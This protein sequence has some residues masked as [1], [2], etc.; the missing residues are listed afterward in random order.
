MDADRVAHYLELEDK[1]AKIRIQIH[2]KLDNQKHI[3][4]ILSA[5]EENIQNLDTNDTSKN[6]VH[7]MVSLM[8]L[9]DQAIDPNTHKIKDLS[10][11]SST[12]YLLDIIF[13]YAPKQLLKSKFSE[14]LTKIAPCITDEGASAALIRSAIGCLES[15]LIAQDA[16]IWNN[17]Q[18]LTVTPRRGLQGL[19]ELSLDP[20]PKIRKRAAEAV[21]NIL[22]NPPA[23]PT[24]E[25]VASIF[26]ASF[27]IKSLTSVMNEF[28][29]TSNKKLR[30]QSGPNDLNTKIIHN[31][32]FISKVISSNQ[33]PSPQ[34]EP[35][36]DLLLEVTKSSDQFL[37]TAAFECFESLFN[38]LSEQSSTLGL[39]DNKFLNVLEIIYSL[40]PSNNDT[41][42][43]GAWIAVVVKSLSSY[44]VHQPLKAMQKIP[45]VFKLIS[46]Y[47]ASESEEIYTSASQCLIAILTNAIRDELLLELPS[48]TEATIDVVDGLLEEMSVLITDF[49]SIKYTH[50][51]KEILNVLAAA[52]TK[53]RHRANPSFI[54]LLVIVDQWRIN[55][56]NYMEY[57]NEV[58]KVIGSAIS[59]MGPDIVLSYLPLNL[60]NPT[61]E[62]PGR[63]W[64]LPILRDYTKNTRLLTF[65][66]EIL[67]LIEVF[68]DKCKQLN[69][70]SVQLKVFQTVIDQLWSTLPRF[71]ELP[72]DL[73]ESFTSDFASKLSSILYSKVELR[74]TICHALKMLVDSNSAYA[75]GALADNILLQESFP[76]QNAKDNLTYLSK[77]SP[78]ILSVLFNV[79][80]QTAPNARGYILETIE[81]FIKITTEEDLQTTFNKVCTLLNSAMDE[82]SENVQKGKP[83][84][85]ATLLDL[86]VCMVKYVPASSY[87]ALF[88]IFSITV[89]SVDALTQKRAYRIVT[90]LSE[91]DAGFEALSGFISDITKVFVETSD[92]TQTSTRSVRLSAI[93]ALVSMLPSNQMD[94][95]VKVVPEVILA[96]KDVNEKSRETAF[97]TLIEMGKKMNEPNSVVRLSE[98]PGYD[99]TTPDQPSSVTEFFKIMSAGLIGESQHMVS[100]TITA[101]AC[102]VFEFKDEIDPSMLLEIYDTIQ[103][104]LT[105]NS[106]EIAKSAIGYIKVCILGLPVELM[107]DKVPELLPK[108]L[109]WSNEHT[110]HFKAKVKNIIER[111][112]RRFGYELVEQAFPEEDRKL[113]TNIRKARNRNSKKGSELSEGKSNATSAKGSRFMSAFDEVVY[114]SSDDENDDTEVSNGKGKKASKQF[115][116]EGE[117]PLDLLDSQTL[118]HIS[119][120]NVRNNKK[121]QRRKIRDDEA[122]SFDDEGKLVVKPG[123]SKTVNE[124]D[125]LMSVTSGINA[126]LDAVK[127]GPIR[128]QKNKLKFKKNKD[129]DDEDDF[130]NSPKPTKKNDS[131][132]KIGKGSFKKNQKFKSRRKL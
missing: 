18:A 15:Q 37:V 114:D 5:V 125:P 70:E 47:L 107:H 62:Q 50:C 56:N 71:C 29:V 89:N 44:A 86:V 61:D 105:S 111:M 34:I 36:C 118:A 115:I 17:T 130:D 93:K 129:A 53:L 52:F 24:A 87:S 85:S 75:N 28:S 4:I 132:N 95:I 21:F 40:K 73:Q 1:L 69:S 82:E 3:A 109:R 51:G 26:I 78:N 101:Y 60:E 13:H 41:H 31:I 39:A 48:N 10:L 84:L 122:F 57:R 92:K 32:R 113:L 46:T 76:V 120:T 30:N 12:C 100:A 127:N 11:L 102:V 19:L 67:P 7:Y 124:E 9:L 106:R 59:G 131:R 117:N 54:K 126:Y 72:T 55:E 23:A 104:Y 119:T 49:L 8:S 22:S 80:S 38:S 74:T 97:E 63:A 2:S 64:L 68:E 6:L 58:E 25:H 66:N 42:L 81:S 20:R 83:Q 121:E 108:L 77:M 33:W 90:R 16:Q 128:G 88:S 65:I 116:I 43:A 27:C 14:I 103:L 98:I 45:E 123:S 91:L 99:S 35:L 96:T 110:G 94:F 79:Y 112:I